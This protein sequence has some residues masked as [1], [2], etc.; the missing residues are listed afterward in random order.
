MVWWLDDL[1]NSFRFYIWIEIQDGCHHTS[2][3][4]I[5]FND[6][7]LSIF[8]SSENKLRNCR[9]LFITW[10]Y[11]RMYTNVFLRNYKL[12][13]TRSLNSPMQICFCISENPDCLHHRH[14]T[15]FNIHFYG[16]NVLNLKPQITLK[17]NMAAMFN[18][19]VMY[20]VY[21]F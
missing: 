19:I 9:I 15:K 3:F 2:E 21:V 10:L 6:Q 13:C 8:F 18:C 1:L 17:A 12:N 14:R 11:A 5:C 7:K 20:K 4:N 16:E